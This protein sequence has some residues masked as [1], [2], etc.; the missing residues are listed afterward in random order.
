MIISTREIQLL[1][2]V[3]ITN[4]NSKRELRNNYKSDWERKYKVMTKRT[5]NTMLTMQMCC[6][7]NDEFHTVYYLCAL[8]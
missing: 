5:V 6:C 7:R 1:I 2:T 4:D 8:C 3:M